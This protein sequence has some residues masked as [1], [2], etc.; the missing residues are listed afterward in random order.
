MGRGGFTHFGRTWEVKQAMKGAISLH[1]I[2]LIHF[3]VEWLKLPA[4]RNVGQ[5]GRLSEQSCWK[6]NSGNKMAFSDS[7]ACLVVK[8]SY[9]GNIGVQPCS[10]PAPFLHKCSKISTERPSK[11]ITNCSSFHIVRNSVQNLLSKTYNQRFN[12]NDNVGQKAPT[13][14]TRNTVLSCQINTLQLTNAPKIT[15]RW[16]Q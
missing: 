5:R 12:R 10:S 8:T 14:C 16:K 6:T 11:T 7:V 15:N 9:S 2:S 3:L 13:L 1:H 4:M